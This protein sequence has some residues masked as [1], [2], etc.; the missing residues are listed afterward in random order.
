MQ[1]H[2]LWA[3]GPGTANIIPV[4]VA[5]A[6]HSRTEAIKTGLARGCDRPQLLHSAGDPSQPGQDGTR[7]P[8]TR[9]HPTSWKWL[10]GLW[11]KTDL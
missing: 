6:P 4:D 5:C 8:P 11:S 1:E 7:H 2:E 9:L 3:S 10:S